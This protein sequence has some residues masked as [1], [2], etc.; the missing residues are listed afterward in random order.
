MMACRVGPGGI[1]RP[2]AWLILPLSALVAWLSIDLGPRALTA[3]DR[4]GAEARREADLATFTSTGLRQPGFEPGP[5]R[6]QRSILT[7]ELLALVLLLCCCHWAAGTRGSRVVPHSSTSADLRGQPAELGWDPLR[8]AMG[9]PT[10][11]LPT[12]LCRSYAWDHSTH[13]TFAYGSRGMHVLSVPV[14]GIRYWVLGV[15]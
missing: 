13:C 12:H 4:I 11:S 15:R 2:L 14:L 1:Y 6:W 10:A 5:L 9:C 3:V 8:R 7:T